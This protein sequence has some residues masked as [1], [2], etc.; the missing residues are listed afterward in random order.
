[1][2]ILLGLFCTFYAFGLTEI[3]FTVKAL[4]LAWDLFREFRKR[5]VSVK[6]NTT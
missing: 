4:N 3:L 1:M 5:T 6:L 2:Y